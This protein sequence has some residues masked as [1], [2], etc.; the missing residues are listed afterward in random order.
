MSDPK[1]AERPTPETYWLIERQIPYHCEWWVGNYRISNARGGEWTT[2]AFKAQRFGDRL[3]AEHHAKDLESWGIT[4]PLYVT[5]HL[6]I[7]P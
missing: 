6:D 5:E 7:M 2:D 1:G 4:G 3:A